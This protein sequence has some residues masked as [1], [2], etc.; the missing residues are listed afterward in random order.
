M[1]SDDNEFE[2]DSLTPPPQPVEDLSQPLVKIDPSPQGLANAIYNIHQRLVVLTATVN[3]IAKRIG[4]TVTLEECEAAQRNCPARTAAT[5]AAAE[6][7]MRPKRKTAEQP[8]KPDPDATWRWLGLRVPV[9]VGIVTLL[10]M[11]GGAWWWTA[12]T[13]ASVRE[14]Q[15]ALKV[16]LVDVLGKQVRQVAQ[17]QRDTD[18]VLRKIVSAQPDSDEDVVSGTVAPPPRKRRPR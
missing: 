12:K 2:A 17:A 8:V 9:L 14:G 18:L 16:Q 13:F 10:G 7:F 15:T 4:A 1:A 5:E 6:A 3:Q 11:I